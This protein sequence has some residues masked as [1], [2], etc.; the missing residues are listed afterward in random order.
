LTSVP[1]RKNVWFRSQPKKYLVPSR[2]KNI[3]SQFRLENFF[4]ISPPIFPLGTLLYV[5]WIY[6]ISLRWHFP[7]LYYVFSSL[8]AH[9]FSPSCS[10]SMDIRTFGCFSTNKELVIRLHPVSDRVS[11]LAPISIHTPSR[12]NNELLGIRAQFLVSRKTSIALQVKKFWFSTSWT[13]FIRTKT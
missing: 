12:S 10:P 6:S 7:F 9:R 5:R 11:H 1:V 3:R 4:G 8:C 13:L 2:W